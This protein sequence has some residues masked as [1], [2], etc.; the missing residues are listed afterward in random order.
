MLGVSACDVRRRLGGDF[1]GWRNSLDIR[2]KSNGTKMPRSCLRAPLGDET[3]P[4]G[5]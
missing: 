1:L 2:E 5:V 4:S 3:K